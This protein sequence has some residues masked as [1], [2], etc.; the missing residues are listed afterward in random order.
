MTIA[1]HVKSKRILYNDQLFRISGNTFHSSY[2]II[3]MINAPR[4]DM[5]LTELQF[6]TPTK[7][8]PNCQM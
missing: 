5:P 8:N 1:G 7:M 4:Q 3:L 2:K 6:D